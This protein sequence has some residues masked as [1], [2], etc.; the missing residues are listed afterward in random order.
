MYYVV[1]RIA[2]V[3]HKGL[4]HHLTPVASQKHKKSA[5]GTHLNMEIYVGIRRTQ[6]IELCRYVTH[7]VIT[8]K[9]DKH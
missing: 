5:R 2:H 6:S 1:G 3:D 8:R 4:H 7:F 9:G